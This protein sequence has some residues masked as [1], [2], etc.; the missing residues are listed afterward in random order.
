MYY[1][2]VPELLAVVGAK[3]VTQFLV[4]DEAGLSIALQNCFRS[5]MTQNPEFINQQLNL[6]LT[7]LASLG[8]WIK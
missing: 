4:S 2:A 5:L 7:R 1:T 3:H 6:L 8:L